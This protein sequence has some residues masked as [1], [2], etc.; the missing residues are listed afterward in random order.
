MSAGTVEYDREGNRLTAATPEEME[1]LRAVEEARKKY[2]PSYIS[3]DEAMKI[4]EQLLSEDLMLAARVRESSTHWPEGMAP[5]SEIFQDL[6]GGAGER[7]ETQA[8]D[9]ASLFTGRQVGDEG[10]AGKA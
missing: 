7:T 6:P 4:P 1:R 2:D 8:V 10:E 5:V 3:H 9:S